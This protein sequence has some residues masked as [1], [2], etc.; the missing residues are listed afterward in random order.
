MTNAGIVHALSIHLTPGAQWVLTGDDPA[1]LI[2][3]DTVQ[4]QPSLTA[5]ENACQGC[6]PLATEFAALTTQTE[7]INFLAKQLG[8]SN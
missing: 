5:I 4:T 1:N 7:Q 2:W 6:N 8:L 3:I